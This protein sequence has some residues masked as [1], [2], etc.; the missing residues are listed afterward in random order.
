MEMVRTAKDSRF[1]LTTREHILSGAV[2]LSARL[3]ENP[4]LRDRIVLTLENYTFGERAR[5]LYNHLY[6]SDLPQAHRDALLVDE[7][8]LSVIHHPHFNPR[9][10]E[11]LSTYSR[12]GGVPAENFSQH[13]GDLLDNPEKIW[14]HAFNQQISE[15]A[16]NVI[17][18]MCSAGMTSAVELE[19]LFDSLHADKA[20]KYNFKISSA[21]FRNALREVDGAFLRYSGGYVLFLNPSIKEYVA[22]LVCDDIHTCRDLWSSLLRF[23]QLITLWRLA[24]DKP[25]SKLAQ[26]LRDPGTAFFARMMSMLDGDYFVWTSN[27]EGGKTIRV[28]DCPIEVRLGFIAEYCEA[29]ESADIASEACAKMLEVIGTWTS[30]SFSWWSTPDFVS[31]LSGR[32]WF[33]QHGGE[34]VHALTLDKLFEALPYASTDNWASVFDLRENDSYWEDDH[35]TRLEPAFDRFRSEGLEQQLSTLSSLGSRKSAIESL[36]TLSEK[37][38]VSFTPAITR[39]E[40]EI[41]T[42]EAEE[43]E[44]EVGAGAPTATQETL[45]GM[46]MT[47]DEVRQMFATLSLE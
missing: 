14:D 44:P 17:L 23:T 31:A 32:E 21:D 12:L 15:A 45:R 25:G 30:S 39:L 28:I 3:C 13:V 35:S 5:M 33:M 7:F 36:E 41:A 16:R 42:L 22:A 20:L 46:T 4:V 37:S 8:F 26:H 29:I 40:E 47:V 27:K 2:R 6:F 1:V 11:W 24:T 10:I 19:P 9:L 18:T 34:A 43:E 38:K